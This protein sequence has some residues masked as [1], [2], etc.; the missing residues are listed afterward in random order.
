MRLDDP[1]FQARKREKEDKIVV[2]SSK[3]SLEPGENDFKKQSQS[4][5]SRNLVEVY[6]IHTGFT[7]FKTFINRI[8]NAIQDQSWLRQLRPLSLNLKGSGARDYC[9]FHNGMGHH[10]VDCRH[11]QK[12]LQELVNRGYLK[13]FILNPRKPSEVKV[14][15]EA[16]KAPTEESNE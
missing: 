2:C 4:S 15:K 1:T 3:E 9:T 10:T 8:F 14:Q 5:S 16:P 7:P 12:Q 13:E 6:E 11:L